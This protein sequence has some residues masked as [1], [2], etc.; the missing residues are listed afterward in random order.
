MLYLSKI[1]KTDKNNFIYDAVSNKLINIDAEILEQL[2]LNMFNKKYYDFLTQNKIRDLTKPLNFEIEYTYS[3]E[4]LDW[5]TKNRA[6]SLTLALTEQCNLRCVYC[7]YMPKYLDKTYKLKHMAEDIAIKSIDIFMRAAKQNPSP[8]IGFYGGEPLLQ[9][10]LIKKCVGYC[11]E[12]YPFS[13]PSFDI[14]TNGLLLDNENIVN[15]LIE[16]EFTVAV[17]LDGPQDIHD[18]FRKDVNNKPSFEKIIKNLTQLYHKAPKYFKN[19]ISF[20]AV[21]TPL[22]GSKEQFEFLDKLYGLD[23]FPIEVAQSDYFSEYLNNVNQTEVSS[24]N[25]NFD[26]MNYSVLRKGIL[27]ELAQYHT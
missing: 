7:A 22:T 4:E 5:L 12:K 3:D 19:K 1:I 18:K 13:K 2:E 6:K 11:K 26:K 10:E 20:N 23:V 14:T 24:T 16:N 21:I 27:K 25:R 8:S 9:F 17:S 15:F